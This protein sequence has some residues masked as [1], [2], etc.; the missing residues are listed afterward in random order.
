MPSIPGFHQGIGRVA[1][2]LCAALILIGCA[3]A[4]PATPEPQSGESDAAAAALE[5][6][7]TYGGEIVELGAAEPVATVQVSNMVGTI[8]SFS[9]TQGNPPCA[10]FVQ[11]A[12]SLVF[13]L[14]EGAAALQ[15]G[16]D[17]NVET[18][19]IAAIEGEEIICDESAPFTRTPTL[20]VP[21]PGAGRYGIWVGRMDMQNPASGTLTVTV[22][23]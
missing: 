4:A 21:E 9:L 13:T 19:L 3:A 22:V 1:A 11:A 23:Q 2:L 12:P 20:T 8:P 15:I 10:G 17:G 6:Y 14:A 16:F 7:R 5:A 18:S